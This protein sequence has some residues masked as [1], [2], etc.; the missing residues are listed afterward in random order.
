MALRGP[1][2][3]TVS[4]AML[5]AY[6]LLLLDRSAV[7]SIVVSERGVVQTIGACSLLVASGLFSLAFVRSRRRNGTRR[8]SHTA[9]YLLLAIAFFVG[10]GE[11]LSWGQHLLGYDSPTVVKEL[12]AQDEVTIHNL[13]LL[14]GGEDGERNPIDRAFLIIGAAFTAGVPLLA[15]HGSGMRARVERFVPIVPLL[16]GLLFVGNFVVSRLIELLAP[17]ELGHAIVEIK[18]MNFSG[19]FLL[20][21]FS[22]WRTETPTRPVAERASARLAPRAP[23]AT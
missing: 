6:L 13:D 9:A 12:N 7:I 21:A 8:P 1:I 15:S 23:H 19:V 20:I 11:E 22:C 5:F 2:A 16:Y 18:E 17:A 14:Q 3:L 10:A 4:A